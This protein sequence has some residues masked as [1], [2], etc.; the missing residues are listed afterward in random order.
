MAEPGDGQAVS[1]ACHSVMSAGLWDDCGDST[2]GR[3]GAWGTGWPLANGLGF[4]G[5]ESA[6]KRGRRGMTFHHQP[7]LLPPAHQVSPSQDANT[8]STGLG[9]ARRGF[10]S[11]ICTCTPALAIGQTIKDTIFTQLTG[12]KQYW[13][14]DF[15]SLGFSRSKP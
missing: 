6:V 3:G 12:G 15:V 8:S 4:L 9:Q 10:V 2:R 11:I 1:G 13:A 7:T 14:I 5:G